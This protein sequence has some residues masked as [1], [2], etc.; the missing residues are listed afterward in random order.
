MLTFIVILRFFK[1]E[2]TPFH[3]LSISNF[4]FIEEEA[5]FQLFYQYF[6]PPSQ[7]TMGLP[8]GIHYKPIRLSL[9]DVGALFHSSHENGMSIK[10][11]DD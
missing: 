1:Y 2:I 10:T 5:K 11:I 9:C 3:P 7:K 6:Y 4:N 8:V